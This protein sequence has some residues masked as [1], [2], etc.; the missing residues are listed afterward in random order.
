VPQRLRELSH[1]ELRLL[2]GNR[3]SVEER[4]AWRRTYFGRAAFARQRP[5]LKDRV[6]RVV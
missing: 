2:A 6:V 4:I 3:T 1:V 5:W